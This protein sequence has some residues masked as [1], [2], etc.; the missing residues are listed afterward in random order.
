L[1]LGYE[2]ITASEQVSLSERYIPAESRNCPA[3]SPEIGQAG[4]RR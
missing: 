1:S 3:D 4:S 2:A